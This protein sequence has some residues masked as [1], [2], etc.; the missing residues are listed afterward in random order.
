MSLQRVLK[1]SLILKA[2][3]QGIGGDNGDESSCCEPRVDEICAAIK[4][5]RNGKTPGVDMITADL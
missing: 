5:L 1:K 3:P 4:L 2:K